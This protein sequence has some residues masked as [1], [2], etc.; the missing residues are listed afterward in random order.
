MLYLGLVK[1]FIGTGQLSGIAVAHVL[2]SL[3][4]LLMLYFLNKRYYG[5]AL[6]PKNKKLLLSTGLWVLF[7]FIA[8]VVVKDFVFSCLISALGAPW[9][10]L[11][12]KKHE[13]DFLLSKI[14]AWKSKWVK[15]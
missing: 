11:S 6:L 9:F 8:G 4:T 13:R 3:V 7:A 12:S 15:I 14:S 10:I 1:L 2:T 5:M